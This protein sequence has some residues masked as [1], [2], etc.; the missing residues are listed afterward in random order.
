MVGAAVNR[1]SALPLSAALLAL[2]TTAAAEGIRFREVSESWQIDFRHHHGGSGERYMVE[3]MVGGV[4]LF[5]FDRDGDNDLFFVDGGELPGYS[6]P[7]PRSRLFR[8]DGGGRFVDFTEA[9]GIEVDGYGCGGSAA[10]YDGDGDLD[11][12]VTLFGENRLFRNDGGH[13]VEVGAQAGVADELWS[14]SAGFAD[15]DRDGDLDLYVANYVNFGFDNH[16]FCGDEEKGTRGYCHPGAYEGLPDRF[17]R[18]LGD[19]R[20]REET[21]AAGLEHEGEAGLGLVFGDLDDDGWP[22]L[23]VANDADP[24]F[25]FRNKGDGTFED[26]SLLSGTAYSD[27]GSPEAGMGVDLADFD[28]DG[29]LDIFVTNFELETNALYRNLGTGLFTD[30][31]FTSNIAEP[32]LLK[33]AFGVAAADYD[34]DRDLDLVIA[35]GHI[36]DNA[37]EMNS[38]SEYAQP[39][40]TMVNDG[41]GRFSELIDDGMDAV[42]V[43]RGLSTG[44]LD[45]D[46]DLDLA[47]VNSNDVAEVYEN[48]GARGGWLQARLVGRSGNA[49]GIGARLALELEGAGPT[50]IREVRTASSYLSQGALDTHFGLGEAPRAERLTVRWPSGRSSEYRRLAAGKRFVLFEAPSPA[51]GDKIGG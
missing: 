33:L 11:L 29:R 14:A 16:R 40:Q 39:N 7:T 38:R 21:G 42:R 6:G 32:S 41:R 44:D 34:Q 24:N 46:G 20:F 43:S 22:D 28:L 27:A 5:D 13:F 3:T 31:R 26:L 37:A 17:Y 19:G 1:R 48:V 18:N 8:N 50:Q 47:I 10:D 36:L 35:N 15:V 30:S 2:S 51:V 45:G 12:Y 9:A 4:V 23:Y 49:W 25:F